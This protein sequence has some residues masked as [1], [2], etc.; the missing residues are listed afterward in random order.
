VAAHRPPPPATPAKGSW[1]R[2]LASWSIFAVSKTESYSSFCGAPNC[3]SRKAI[4]AVPSEL[5]QP[6]RKPPRNWPGAAEPDALPVPDT[7]AKMADFEGEWAYH[8]DLGSLTAYLVGLGVP[9][10][11]AGLIAG[12]SKMGEPTFWELDEARRPTAH[13]VPASNT[14]SLSGSH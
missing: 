10:F 5:G 12:A 2:W 13:T 8:E 1:S 11:V 9:S 3:G 14:R 6:E 7:S 4:K